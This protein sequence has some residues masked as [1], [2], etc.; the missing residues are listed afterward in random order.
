MIIKSYKAIDDRSII[1]S[2]YD[3]HKQE[4]KQH[5]IRPTMTELADL[6]NRLERSEQA[7]VQRI[8]MENGG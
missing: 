6:F 3:S 1:V 5:V 4:I 8:Q 2:V 7:V